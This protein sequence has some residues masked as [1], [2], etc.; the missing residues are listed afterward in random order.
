MSECTTDA[1]EEQLKETFKEVGTKHSKD[2][3]SSTANKNTTSHWKNSIRELKKKLPYATGR[4]S[5]TVW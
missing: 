2:I 5:K 4:K 3:N 1:F